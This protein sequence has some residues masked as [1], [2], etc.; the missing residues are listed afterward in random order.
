MRRSRKKFGSSKINDFIKITDGNQK[1]NAED[2][3]KKLYI[4]INNF[5]MLNSKGTTILK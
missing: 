3:W 5:D 2:W 4:C 1:D